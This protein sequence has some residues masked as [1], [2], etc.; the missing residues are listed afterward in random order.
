MNS[1]ADLLGYDLNSIRLEDISICVYIGKDDQ[2]FFNLNISLPG[3]LH[4]I[5]AIDEF[6]FS[7]FPIAD[8]KWYLYDLSSNGPTK[9]IKIDPLSTNWMK[10]RNY[11]IEKCK[12]AQSLGIVVATL[13][14]KGYL[15]VVKHIQKLAKFCGVR[16]YLISVGKVNPAK[17]ANFLDIDCFV[18]IGCPENKLITSREFYKPLLSTFEVEVALNP[19][20]RQRMPERYFVEFKEV[21]PNGKLFRE[22][23]EMTVNE[24]DVSL[25]TG[26]VRLAKL[27][28]TC[29]NGLEDGDE[30]SD[31]LLERDNLKM[32][33][34]ESHSSFQN[35]SWTG[36]DPALGKDN[37]VRIVEGRSGIAMKYDEL[38]E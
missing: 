7:S 34:M 28:E 12:D 17:L 38:N 5:L 1:E 31:A 4:R 20:W 18:L 36:L 15:D 9:F 2:S 19:V 25:V 13:T 30:S 21:L 33:E 37:P 22:F 29:A 23:S 8:M 3:T 32:M 10:R 24:S 27:T 14:A 11:Y 26:K 35:R 16:T 6:S